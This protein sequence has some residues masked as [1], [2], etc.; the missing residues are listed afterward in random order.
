MPAITNVSATNTTPAFGQTQYDVTVVVNFTNGQ[1]R[2]LT[3]RSTDLTPEYKHTEAAPT[4]GILTHTFTGIE[5]DNGVLHHFEAYFEDQPTCIDNDSYTSP[6]AK[7]LTTF[8]PTIGQQ[9]CNTEYVVNFHV[10]FAALGGNLVVRDMTD[11]VDIYNQTAPVGTSFDGTSI[12]LTPDGKSHTLRI[13]FTSDPT[14]Y[15][16]QNVD[17]PKMPSLDIANTFSVV[18][19]NGQVTAHLSVTFTNQ[20]GDLVLLDEND[21]PLTTFTA[22]TEGTPYTYDWTMA[23]DG[24][25]HTAKAYFTSLGATCATTLPLTAPLTPTVTVTKDAALSTLSCDGTFSYVYDIVG[26]NQTGNLMVQGAGELAP[27]NYGPVATAQH[28]VSGVQLTA[29][30]GVEVIRAWYD[31]RATC[32]ANATETFPEAVS[33]ALTSTKSDLHCDGTFDITLTVNF[34]GQ[35]GDLVIEDANGNEID[36]QTAPV[37]P[38]SFVWS[39][40]KADGSNYSAKAYFA[41]ATDCDDNTAQTAPVEM[42]INDLSTTESIIYCNGTTFDLTINVEAENPQADI[43]VKEG[44]T[45]LHRFTVATP[46]TGKIPY[47]IVLSDIPTDQAA[48]TIRAF[49]DGYEACAK[50]WTYTAPTPNPCQYRYDT[51]CVGQGYNRYGL[52]LPAQTVAGDQ[53]HQVVDTI[54]EL[55]VIDLPQVS[56]TTVDP[57]CNSDGNIVIPYTIIAGEPNRF[58]VDFDDATLPDLTGLVLNGGVLNV[59]VPA[60]L[61]AGI[62]NADIE[63][64]HTTATCSTTERFTFEIAEDNLI[65]SKWTDVLLINNADE[66][67]V[68]YQWY[69]DGNLMDGE[70]QQRL[71]DP[72]GLTGNYYCLLTT[73]DGQKIRTCVISFS[74]APRS[75]DLPQPTKIE[76]A[77]K[78]LRGGEQLNISRSDDGEATVT[79]FSSTGKKVTSTAIYDAETAVT[80]PEQTGLYIVVVDN[81]DV[82]FTDKIIV[83]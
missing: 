2:Q 68:E 8:T 61:P 55:R 74:E 33:I 83:E 54:I 57:V 67:F 45:E 3:I 76:I 46:L 24:A 27:T 79:F 71:Y 30:T 40:L 73:T 14:Y 35:R 29:A 72:Q 77:P 56:L 39:G 53:T 80:T 7:M 64:Y 62:Y 5:T 58:D 36:R 15:L 11:N 63:F 6:I 1:G 18:D 75:A 28:T 38:Y 42:Y 69:Q 78:R 51:I 60:G 9:T 20:T 44:T 22:P 47:S 26:T 70:T 37:S 81:G 31:D 4:T 23:A 25:A 10:D 50:T 48:H 41:G 82:R 34:S 43:I 16:E 49:F 17:A 12:V 66:R 32:L 21:N 52:V 19:C 13:Y 59:T 65:Y